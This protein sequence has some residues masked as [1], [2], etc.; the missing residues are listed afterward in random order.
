MLPIFP[1]AKGAMRDAFDNELFRAMWAVSSI[2]KEIRV[3][4]QTEGKEA[5]YERE[6]GTIIEMDYKL[7]SVER[8]WHF[9]EAQGLA[10]EAFLQIAADLGEEMGNKMLADILKTVGQVTQEVGNVVNCEGKGM[11]FEK[12]LEMTANVHTEFDDFGRPDVKTFVGSPEACR[13]YEKNVKEWTS[14]PAKQTAIAQVIER[15][16]KAFNEREARRRMVD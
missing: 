16:W 13:E 3:R 1:K 7:Q 10:P 11:T 4:P 15:H 9:E 8:R 12:F 6:D 14:D 5:S 2:L